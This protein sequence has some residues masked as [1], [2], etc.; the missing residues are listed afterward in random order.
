MANNVATYH[1][2]NARTGWNPHETKLTPS[3]VAGPTFG[4][5]F[6]YDAA[7]L[8][9]IMY[10]QPLYAERLSISGKK[11]NVVFVATE[12]ASIYAF[13]ADTFNAA[14]QPWLW[15]RSLVNPGEQAADGALKSTPVIDSANGIMYA[16][17]RLKD[18][19]GNIFFRIHALDIKTGKDITGVIPFVIDSN[20]VPKISGSG[21]P[22]STPGK[23]YFDPSQ[24]WNRPGLLLAHKT[25]Y[26]GFGS[27]G[28]DPPY[29]GWVMGFRTSDLHLIGRFCT[30]PDAAGVGKPCWS[31]PDLGGG[32]WQ[33]GF[34]LAASKDK[35]IYCMTANGIFGSVS[36]K[37]ARN[38]ADSLI[39]LNDKL[40]LVGSFTPPD[41]L[42]LTAQDIDFGSAGATVLPYPG[43]REKFIVGCGKDANVYLLESAQ[44]TP[45]ALGH[46]ANFRST[47]RLA[48]N[49]GAIAPGC[50]T[51]P[52]VWGGPAYYRGAVGS[53]IYYCGSSGPL[54]ALVL[55]MN[56][57]IYH[58]WQSTPGGSWHGQATL[59][60]D[61]KEVAIGSNHNG[62]LELVYIGTDDKLYH[63]RQRK[64]GGP[65]RGKAP[66]HG[67]ARQITI[68][69]NQSGTL[70]V[71]YIGADAKIYHDWQKTP[72]GHWHGKAALGGSARQTAVNINKNGTLEIFYVG[73]DDMIY[74][75]WQKTPGGTWNGEAPLPLAPLG[76]RSDGFTQIGAAQRLCVGL[77]KNGT[78]EVFYIGS[79]YLIYHNWQTSPGGPWWGG[80]HG[81]TPLAPGAGSRAVAGTTI[82]DAQQVTVAV[83]QSGALEIFYIGRD[84]NLYHNWQTTPGGPWNGEAPLGGSAKY[85]TV[86][87]NK[88]GT[89]EVFYVGMDDQLYHNWQT[90][91]GGSWHGQ[92]LLGGTARQVCVGRNK[93]GALEVFYAA[94][95]L[96]QAYTAAS[97][98]NVTPQSEAIPNEGG[99]IPFVTSNGSKRRTGVVW[100]V[101]RPDGANQLRLRA[102][103][104]ADLTKG[105]LFDAVIGSWSGGGAFLAPIVVNGKAYIASD[106]LL[107]V[108]GII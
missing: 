58:N 2:D 101:L 103:D 56:E 73:T 95:A 48:S 91:P 4:L 5:L 106:R 13:D 63:N 85:I 60:G 47:T 27:T 21:Q 32:I 33:A 55:K 14:P 99:F 39:K 8:D 22:Q 26:A 15:R 96:T 30:T 69:T 67:V 102:Y 34:G 40:K 61:A 77:N 90:T 94:A 64:P 88:I 81:E 41:P 36:G 54:Q 23:V 29:H 86:G 75:N 62:T 59:S 89:L 76:L 100:G 37:P 19:H 7:V 25:V 11:H 12:A 49:P 3:V 53:V 92:A 1:Y 31:D 9:A 16:I 44:L 17:G 108:Y 18:S 20:S 80:A 66:L 70:E 72:G 45:K 46:V 10:A 87:Q 57:K 50:G 24:H 6:Q 43:G 105:H 65:W 98:P 51:G 82:G 52:G 74:H 104:A 84:N 83:N 107:A 28:D 38:Y 68:G 71:F 97:A 79:D 35:H 78:L 42:A 93:S